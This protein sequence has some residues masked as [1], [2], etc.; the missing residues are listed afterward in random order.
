MASPNYEQICALAK[1]LLDIIAVQLIL[2]KNEEFFYLFDIKY[3]E[4]SKKMNRLALEDS[5]M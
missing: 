2:L 1:K 4:E 5:V 3:M